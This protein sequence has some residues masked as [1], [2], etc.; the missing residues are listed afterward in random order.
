LLHNNIIATQETKMEHQLTEIEE[1]E[2]IYCDMHKDVYGVKARWIKF[3]SVEQGQKALASLQVALDAEMENQ[4]KCQEEAI[5]AFEELALSCGGV[6]TAKR[7]QHE[8]YKT[9]G[10]DEYLCYHLG[11]PYGYFTKSLTNPS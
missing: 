4:R 2:S 6:E 5:K 7:W 10:D 1:L 3:D 11:L 9:D 8:A